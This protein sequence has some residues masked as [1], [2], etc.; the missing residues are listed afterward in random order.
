MRNQLLVQDTQHRSQG[1]D[2][3]PTFVSPQSSNRKLRRVELEDALRD[4]PDRKDLQQLYER[5][6]PLD[7]IVRLLGH[8]V[9]RGRVGAILDCDDPE[10]EIRRILG[11]V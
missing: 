8:R 10:R 7:H 9:D 5:K 2:S 4:L 11:S 1:A 3:G 6:V